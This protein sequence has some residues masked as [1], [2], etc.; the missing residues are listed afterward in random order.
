MAL[1]ADIEYKGIN[2]KQVYIKIEN[3]TVLKM[4]V[5]KISESVLEF[6][7]ILNY[8]IK[9]T[10]ESQSFASEE[11]SYVFNPDLPLYSQT[12]DKLKELYPNATNI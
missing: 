10:K 3:M 5:F 12:Y 11:Y 1:L 4:N 9:S 8:S 2:L 6:T 7:L